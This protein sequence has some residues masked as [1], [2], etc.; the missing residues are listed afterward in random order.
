MWL[1]KGSRERP[2]TS[3]FATVLFTDAAARHVV[4]VLCAGYVLVADVWFLDHACFEIIIFGSLDPFEYV[5][6]EPWIS[7]VVFLDFLI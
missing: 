3:G 6:Q 7:F 1:R 4:F 2:A 5:N